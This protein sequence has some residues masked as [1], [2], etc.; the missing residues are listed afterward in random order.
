MYFNKSVKHEYKLTERRHNSCPST[1]S[2]EKKTLN[3]SS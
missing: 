2:I 3:S 1:Q